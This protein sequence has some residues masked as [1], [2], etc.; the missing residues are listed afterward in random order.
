MDSFTRFS[1][2]IFLVNNRLWFTQNKKSRKHWIYV[3]F[4]AAAACMLPMCLYACL[5]TLGH[6]MTMRWQIVSWEISKIWTS[7]HWPSGDPSLAHLTLQPGSIR[8]AKA[9]CPR[10]VLLYLGQVNL[11]G[12]PI[13][14]FTLLELFYI[15][16]TWDNSCTGRNPE[17]TAPLTIG[18]RISSQYL[19]VVR[20][21]LPC[22]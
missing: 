22:L 18:P 2:F 7:H 12:R 4:C 8:W 3:C 15:P 5:T 16:A 6:E 13:I 11:E 20:V 14:S 17:P 10:S 19:M 21:P 9:W 1:T